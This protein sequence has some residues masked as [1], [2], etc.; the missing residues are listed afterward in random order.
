MEWWNGFLWLD[1]DDDDILPG[2]EVDSPGP[3]FHA[4]AGSILAESAADIFSAIWVLNL[5]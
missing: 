2:A 3:P 5:T 1:D 4:A